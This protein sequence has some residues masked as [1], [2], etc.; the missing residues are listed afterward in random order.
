M[1]GRGDVVRQ[2]GISLQGSGVRHSLDCMR[3]MPYAWLPYNAKSHVSRPNFLPSAKFE[4]DVD[5]LPVASG[6]APRVRGAR[7]GGCEGRG[8]ASMTGMG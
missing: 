6:T 7:P 2:M 1:Q 4:P 8:P 5:Q 3:S